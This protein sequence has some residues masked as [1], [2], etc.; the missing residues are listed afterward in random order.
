MS[1]STQIQHKTPQDAE[2]VVKSF[3]IDD[4][5]KRKITQA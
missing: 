5:K 1:K 4:L 2:F 3:N